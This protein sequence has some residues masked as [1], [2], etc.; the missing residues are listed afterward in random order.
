MSVDWARH[1]PRLAGVAGS[2]SSASKRRELEKFDLDRDVLL[3]MGQFSANMSNPLMMNTLCFYGPFHHLKRARMHLLR[4][5]DLLGRV[6]G[7][8]LGI[9]ELHSGHVTLQRED[10]VV[11]RHPLDG[12]SE[13]E[14]VFDTFDTRVEG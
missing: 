14:G 10:D 13:T 12:S 1:R 8:H 11:F 4:L 9:R 7:D 3:V 6:P 2:V 5:A